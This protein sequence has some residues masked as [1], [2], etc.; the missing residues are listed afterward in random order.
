MT[1]HYDRRMPRRARSVTTAVV[2]ALAVVSLSAACGS[3]DESGAGTGATAS[4][5]AGD[6]T[7]AEL[8]LAGDADEGVDGV[9]AYRV[10]SNDH[11]EGEVDYPVL[12]PPGGPHNPV[13][14]NCGFYDEPI[15]DEHLVHDLE[16]GA[17]W[18]AYAPDLPAAEVD[19]VRELVRANDKTVAAPYD[20]LPP[21]AAVVATAWARQLVLDTVDD[22]RLEEFVVQ[23][24]DG[25][26]APEAGVTCTQSPLGEPK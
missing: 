16:H 9:Q 2:A 18:L 23:Y 20:D 4:T 12:P 6:G 3:D 14:A 10:A 1:A 15:A 11:T 5:S 25:S 22:P 19:A 8:A 17:V 13:W 7:E 26:Q 21:G 24:Q